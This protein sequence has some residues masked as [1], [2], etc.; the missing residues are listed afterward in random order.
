MDVNLVVSAAR[1]R[2]SLSRTLEH[3]GNRDGA[4]PAPRPHPGVVGFVDVSTVWSTTPV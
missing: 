3:L 4:C 1:H 2:A